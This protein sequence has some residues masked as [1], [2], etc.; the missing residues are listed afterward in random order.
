[1]PVLTRKKLPWY[2]IYGDVHFFSKLSDMLSTE[3]VQIWSGPVKA[4]RACYGMSGTD[5]A[6]RATRAPFLRTHAIYNLG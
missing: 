4:L 2:Q 6:Y 3:P 5:A 1:M